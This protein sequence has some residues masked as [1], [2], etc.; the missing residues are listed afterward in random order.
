MV[1]NSERL[2]ERM[3]VVMAEHVRRQARLNLLTMSSDSRQ[4]KA[5]RGQNARMQQ[6]QLRTSIWISECSIG[7]VVVSWR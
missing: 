1:L 7:L 5:L 4:A 3:L 6:R 2:I